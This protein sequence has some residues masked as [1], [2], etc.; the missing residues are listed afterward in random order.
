VTLGEEAPS[1]STGAW[2]LGKRSPSPSARAWHSGKTF[3]KFLANDSVQCCRQMQIS[4]CECPS[5]PSVALGEDGFPRVP[6]FPECHGFC[7]TR[8]SPSSPSAFLPRVPDFWHSGK[9]LTLGEFQFSRSEL[10]CTDVNFIG[11]CSPAMAPES[12][13]SHIFL[14]LPTVP[15]PC[16]QIVLEDGGWDVLMK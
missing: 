4:F 13:K 11:I 16:E 7:N 15:M 6:P 5:S 2:H 3:F 14:C 12:P 10:L 8:E 1:L 9:S